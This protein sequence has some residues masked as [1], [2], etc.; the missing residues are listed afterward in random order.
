MGYD[1]VIMGAGV[2]GAMIARELSK[3]DVSVCVLEKESDVAM[4]ASKANSGIVHAGYDAKRGSLK[5]ILNVQ[6]SKMME[7]IAGELG[8]KFKKNGSLVI[9]FNNEDLKSIAELYERGKKN[10]VEELEIIDKQKLKKLE[11]NIS[12]NAVGALYAPT[13]AI[14]CPYDLTIAAIG[15]AMDNG[16]DLKLEFEVKNIKYDDGYYE[17]LSKNETIKAKIYYK[18]RRA[19]CR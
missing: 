11:P 1:I 15:N 13:G 3:Y 7:R 18:C 12:E 4:G 16:A 10:V 17:I 5:A 14:V 19:V 9:G 2:V 6:G 8:V